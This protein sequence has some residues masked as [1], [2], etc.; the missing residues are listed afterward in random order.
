MMCPVPLLAA[1]LVSYEGTQSAYCVELRLGFS[2]VHKL[3]A[4][5]DIYF[6]EWSCINTALQVYTQ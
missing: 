5:D 2:A 1:S 3:T 4:M 6:K